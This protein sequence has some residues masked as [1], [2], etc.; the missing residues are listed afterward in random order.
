[1]RDKMKRRKKEGREVA[2]FIKILKEH[3]G[4]LREKFKV[5][6]IGVFGSYVK[7]EQ[8]KRSD[9]DILVEFYE[10]V[11]LGYFELKEFLEGVLGTK[12]DLVIKKGIKPRLRNIILEQVIY[13]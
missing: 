9:L 2:M 3:K 10:P 11:G 7:N 1:M 8:R 6:E 13:L 5:K 12:V 4:Y